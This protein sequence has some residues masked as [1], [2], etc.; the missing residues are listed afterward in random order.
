[1]IRDCFGREKHRSERSDMG[2]VGSFEKDNRTLY[3]G[4]ISLR[5]DPEATVRKHF[6]QFG[7]IEYSTRRGPFMSSGLS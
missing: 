2:G 1:M 4:Q 5:A 3:I 7:V 6:A